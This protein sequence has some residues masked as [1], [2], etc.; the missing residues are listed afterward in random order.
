MAA[1]EKV[2]LEERGGHPFFS[3]YLD[4]TALSCSKSVLDSYIEKELKATRG[5]VDGGDG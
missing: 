2:L 5:K 3:G 4:H 1:K